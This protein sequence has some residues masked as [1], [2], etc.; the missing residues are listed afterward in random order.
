[1]RD[2]PLCQGISVRPSGRLP[3]LRKRPEGS[4][5]TGILA[6]ANAR[7]M[8]SLRAWCLV[9][10]LGA[11]LHT[12]AWRPHVSTCDPH[13]QVCAPQRP[14]PSRKATVT[15]TASSSRQRPHEA[16]GSANSQSRLCLAAEAKKAA[17]LVLLLSS[18]FKGQRSRTACESQYL[19]LVCDGM[20]SVFWLFWLSC[21][22]LPTDWLERLL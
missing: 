16:I 18:S 10:R 1:V 15:R 21:H 17:L 14:R 5:V 19:S 13:R 12:K 9:I 7:E 20:C 3:S 11:I 22:Y 6:E 4:F 8:M 2:R